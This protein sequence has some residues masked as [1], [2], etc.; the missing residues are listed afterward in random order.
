MKSL[1]WDPVPVTRTANASKWMYLSVTKFS[2]RNSLVQK[3]KLD[4]DEYLV[5]SERDVLAIVN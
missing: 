3:S 2:T 1:P 5:L 4:Q